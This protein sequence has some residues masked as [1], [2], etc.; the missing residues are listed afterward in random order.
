MWGSILLPVD[1]DLA[2]KLGQLRKRLGFL[3]TLHF[4]DGRTFPKQEKEFIDGAIK[5]FEESSACFRA[6][7]VHQ[8]NW[9]GINT[10][11][12]KARLAGQLLSYPWM[13]Y[14]G[15]VYKIFSRSRIVFDRISLSASG[16][17]TFLAELNKMITRPNKLAGGAS[18]YPI[19]EASVAFV[20]KAI[21]DELQLV[22]ILNG[23]VR[24]SYLL[25]ANKG[26]S[27]EKLDLHNSFLARFPKLVS[28]VKASRKDTEQKINVWHF[29]PGANPLPK[30][31]IIRFR[32]KYP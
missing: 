1:C 5:A 28:F 22:D 7:L 17:A 21:F 26:T 3:H 19:K 15:D 29:D 25:M 8:T 31:R 16:E 23:I 4:S 18:T 13:P 6:I 32:R 12:G 24:V 30:R 14:D 9:D 2:L 11:T 27:E 10:P 20:D